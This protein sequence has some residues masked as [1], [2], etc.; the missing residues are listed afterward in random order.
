MHFGAGVK[1]DIGKIILGQAEPPATIA[2]MLTAA[3][4]V[5]AEQSKR[6]SPGDSALAV[7]E[8]PEESPEDPSELESLS[9]QVESLIDL[10]GAIVAAKKPFDFRNIR[11]YRCNQFGHFQNKCPNQARSN[12]GPNR[13]FPRQTRRQGRNA[14]RRPN[15]SQYPFEAKDNKDNST[16]DHPNGGSEEGDQWMLGIF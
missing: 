15:R 12:T 11:C 2:N 14:F 1:P 9:R 6:G 16:P 4:A 5:E 13:R 7:S 3:E 8:G 10:V